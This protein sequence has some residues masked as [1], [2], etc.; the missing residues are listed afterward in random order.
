[1]YTHMYMYYPN[2][3]CNICCGCLLQRRGLLPQRR[4]VDMYVKYVGTSNDRDRYNNI[5]SHYT[6]YRGTSTSTTK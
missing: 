6:T 2:P 1:M 5:Y 3:S 4:Y